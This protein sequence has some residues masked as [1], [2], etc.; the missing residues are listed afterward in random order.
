MFHI[1]IHIHKNKIL[2]G[3]LENMMYV[4]IKFYDKIYIWRLYKNIKISCRLKQKLIS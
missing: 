4:D 1:F 2:L 3:I